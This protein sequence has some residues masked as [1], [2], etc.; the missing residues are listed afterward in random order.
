MIYNKFFINKFFNE[1]D[2]S[3]LLAILPQNYPKIFGIFE[4]NF[5]NMT[6]QFYLWI[7]FQHY[8]IYK[9]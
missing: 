4:S 1:N 2:L 3:R 5:I 6:K 7:V 8:K 9:N